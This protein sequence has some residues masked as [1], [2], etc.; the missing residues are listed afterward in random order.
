[1][2][3]EKSFIF[4]PAESGLRKTLKE[5]EA[6]ALRYIWTID[7]EGAVSAATTAVV[8]EKLAPATISRASIIFFLN[9]L[10]VQGVL[11]FWDGTGKGGHHKIYFP[12]MDEK[13]YKKHLLKTIIDSMMRDFPEE[14]QEAIKEYIESLKNQLEPV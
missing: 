9:R 7:D 1:M 2:K 4:N 14:T 8:N 13:G 12:L 3:S 10:V 5:Y 6:V 11:G